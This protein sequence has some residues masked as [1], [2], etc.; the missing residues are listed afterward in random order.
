MRLICLISSECQIQ[1]IFRRN[2]LKTLL[3]QKQVLQKLLQLWFVHGVHKSSLV[4]GNKESRGNFF[5]DAHCVTFDIF[6]IFKP[7]AVFEQQYTDTAVDVLC[8]STIPPAHQIIYK[9]VFLLKSPV[10]KIPMSD[11]PIKCI[12]MTVTNFQQ[13]FGFWLLVVVSTSRGSSI[14]DNSMEPEYEYLF[15]LLES[16]FIVGKLQGSFWRFMDS[17][18]K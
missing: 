8:T 17:P 9:C 6:I 12:H 14:L 7:G 11:E 2:K 1:I 15:Q 18:H 16:F 5:P 3:L 10:T 13:H 4:G